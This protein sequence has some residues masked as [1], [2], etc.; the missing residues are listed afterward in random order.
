VTLRCGV[1]VIRL[2]WG[3]GGGTINDSRDLTVADKNLLPVKH[4]GGYMI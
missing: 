1:A 2:T 4:F 3:Y